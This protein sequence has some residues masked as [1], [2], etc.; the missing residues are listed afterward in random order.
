MLFQAVVIVLPILN[1]FKISCKR[2]KVQAIRLFLLFSE[3]I[4]YHVQGFHIE[5]SKR[6]RNWL[7]V[8]QLLY[9]IQKPISVYVDKVIKEFHAK[10]C[11]E[12]H[13]IGDC[14]SPEDSNKKIS[15][16]L[17]I[18]CKRWLRKL[19]EAHEKGGNP[20]WYKNC[21][22]TRWTEDHWE[23]AKFFMPA[24]GS[25]QSGARDAQS[26]DLSSLLNFLESMKDNAFLGKKRPGVD[27]VK[28]FRFQVRNVWAL[29][30]THEITEHDTADIFSTG[31]DVFNDIQKLSVPTENGA[32]LE[33]LKHLKDNSITNIAKCELQ[34]LILQRQLL[35][36]MKEEISIVQFKASSDKRTV[37]EHESKLKKFEQAWNYCSQRM[38]DFESFK[39]DINRQFVNLAEE[40]KSFRSF[41]DDIHEIYKSLEPIPDDLNVTTQPQKEEN[42]P[43]SCLPDRLQMFTARKNE[44]QKVTSCLK[45]G[46]AAVVSLHGG[47][48]FGK[49]AIAIEVSH[50][51]NEY[52]GMCVVLSH[53]ISVSTVDDL[54]RQLC[55]DIGINHEDDQNEKSSLI[56]WLKNINNKFVFVL[57][58]VDCLLQEKTTF[59]NFICLLRR[60]SNQNGQIVTTS[61]TSYEIPE[62][63]TTKIQIDEMTDEECMQ[64]LR[65]KSSEQDEKFLRRLAEL[66]G[67][68]PLAMCIAASQVDDYEKPDDLLRHLEKQPM[69]T[70]GSSET[71]KYVNRAIKLSYDKLENEEKQALVRLAVF[72]GSFSEDAAR[73]VTEQ[74]HLDSKHI[75]KN[76]VRRS[77]IKQ[78][79]KL[80]YS[81]HLL[82]KHFLRDQLQ[83]EEA[84][85]ENDRAKLLMVK[86][87][88]SLAHDLTM[89]SYSNG[90]YKINREALRDEAQNI[91]NVLKICCEEKG[92]TSTIS[93]CLAESNI[94]TSSGRHFSLFVRTIIPGYIVNKFLQ[95]C[96]KLAEESRKEAE[97]MN[98]DCLLADQERIKSIG[99]SVAGLDIKMQKIKREFDTHYRVLKKNESVCAHYFHLCG[100]YL[101]RKS[102][103]KEEKERFNMQI[104]AREQLQKSLELREKFIHTP[105]GEADVVFTLLSLGTTEK[106][107]AASEF[108]NRRTRKSAEATQKAQDY[109]EEAKTLAQKSLGEHELTSSCYKA[110]GDFFLTTKDL[111]KAVEIYTTAKE[112]RKKLGL[113]ASERYVFLLNNLGQC[114]IKDKRAN[115]AIAVLEDARDIAE[116]LAENDEI[117]PCQA[118]V[119]RSLA[120]AN[121]LQRN[122]SPDVANYARKAL[123]FEK[124]YT[125]TFMELQRVLK[126]CN[127]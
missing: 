94:F 121:D 85:A 55:I 48:G 12:L 88:L 70:L 127:T 90:G 47:P 34:C 103:T 96:A 35:N 9:S 53:L 18:S 51:L 78:P 106:K 11:E 24:L 42:T 122:Y 113:D 61:R 60:Y 30:A 59:Y 114:F 62:L 115:E 63:S 38:S 68:I 36:Q 31:N 3:I 112:M 25:N 74:D 8:G 5:I 64:L 1:F 7:L 99:E 77:L 102:E 33:H 91:Q 19:G 125:T 120:L 119:Y 41:P 2:G 13:A 28:E 56:L 21:D 4:F 10:L 65:N 32:S 93:I 87:C 83:N 20:L 104:D 73:A 54:I 45:D 97:K 82:I 107:I 17:C 14:R 40:V 84:K 109:Y 95:R 22:S 111:Q 27:Q 81:I 46:T 6:H 80:R 58:D 110:L 15:S 86:Y 89:K 16:D 76:L 116:K 105:E 98:F 71:N 101:L 123:L 72:N 75:L 117:N 37:E 23:V 100:R 39:E 43:A 69:K 118:K 49:T 57:D 29:A 52:H 66:C 79:T 26:T 44:V 108:H 126:T 67:N 124:P 50:K 92:P